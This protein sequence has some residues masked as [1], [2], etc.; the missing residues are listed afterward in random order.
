ME[1]QD[2]VGPGW[3]LSQNSH[4]YLI[5]KVCWA[6]PTLLVSEFELTHLKLST[7]KC[8][9]HKALRGQAFSSSSRK[10]LEDE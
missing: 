7:F 1:I 9:S 5:S 8:H 2:A 10:S 6:L 4:F 3:Q